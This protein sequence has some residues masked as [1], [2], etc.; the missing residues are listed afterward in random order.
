M[1]KAEKKSMR[2]TLQLNGWNVYLKKRSI[3][4]YHKTRNFT[5]I[6]EFEAYIEKNA[7]FDTKQRRRHKTTVKNEQSYIDPDT[8]KQVQV[9]SGDDFRKMVKLEWE[10]MVNVDKSMYKAIAEK[11]NN[12]FR[13]RDFSEK[14]AVSLPTKYKDEREEMK[15]I[16]LGAR[17]E[18]SNTL[19]QLRRFDQF[20]DLKSTQPS[21]N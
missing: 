18:I 9:V 16:F 10:G 12:K 19:K 8:H 13:D 4:T 3:E 17:R 2:R 15:Q 6:E 1:P 20:D 7:L 21:D 14:A 5:D 11:L